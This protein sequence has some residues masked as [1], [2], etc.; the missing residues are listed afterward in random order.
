M[1]S[2]ANGEDEDEDENEEEETESAIHAKKYP[3]YTNPFNIGPEEIVTVETFA[4]W[5]EKFDAEKAANNPKEEDGKN[6][7][8]TGREMWQQNLVKG[9]EKEKKEKKEEEEVFWFN[10]GI[11]DI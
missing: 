1:M 7:Q 11:Y 2:R 9:L 6:N 3:A 4:K 10:E 8:L 5:R